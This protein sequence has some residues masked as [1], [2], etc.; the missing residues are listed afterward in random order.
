VDLFAIVSYGCTCFKRLHG[1]TANSSDVICVQVSFFTLWQ[2]DRLSIASIG[3]VH[4]NSRPSV[5]VHQLD[6]WRRS[7]LGELLCLNYNMDRCVVL[8]TR[9]SGEHVSSLQNIYIE[10]RNKGYSIVSIKH[11]ETSIN[12]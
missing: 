12:I 8:V 7:I 5:R 4:F 11:I 3:L 6:I 2:V 9:K 1:L 10:W